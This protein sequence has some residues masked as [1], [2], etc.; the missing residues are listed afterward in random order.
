[1]VA[2]V[3]NA[4]LDQ[5]AKLRDEVSAR[6]K[7]EGANGAVGSLG[8]G[9]SAGDGRMEPPASTR[10]TRQSGSQQKQLEDARLALDNIVQHSEL[11]DEQN[12]GAC[13]VAL[14]RLLATWTHL[15]G[16]LRG[17]DEAERLSQKQQKEMEQKEYHRIFPA[18]SNLE[19]TVRALKE[20]VHKS[21][22]AAA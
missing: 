15:R 10:Q 4:I 3:K 6:R 22:H 7:E 5:L 13:E 11:I 18:K 21:R 8:P 12:L 9:T 1:V 14:Q 19:A 20:K 2:D 16:V 17:L